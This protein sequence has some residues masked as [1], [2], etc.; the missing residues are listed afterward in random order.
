VFA[1]DRS[2]GVAATSLARSPWLRDLAV[3]RDRIP[4]DERADMP[5]VEESFRVSFS[6]AVRA[7]VATAGRDAA[8]ADEPADARLRRYRDIA[9]L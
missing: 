8:Q 6:D 9:R 4:P 5:E 3:R 2:T 7:G 1:Q